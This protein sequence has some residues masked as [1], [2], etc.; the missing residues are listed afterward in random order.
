MYQMQRAALQQRAREKDHQLATLSAEREELRRKL[1]ELNH[2][3]QTLL[4]DRG[5]ET[6]KEALPA[7]ELINDNAVNENDSGKILLILF[8]LLRHY[9]QPAIIIFFPLLS[10]DVIEVPTVAVGQETSSNQDVAKRLTKQI[11]S[12]IGDIEVTNSST[13]ASFHPCPWCSGRLINV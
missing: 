3:V 2:L 7:L 4:N 8:C 13:E 6:A 11:L 1:Q 9:G 10:L 12:I 5:M